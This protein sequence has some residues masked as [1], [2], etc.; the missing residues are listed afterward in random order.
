MTDMVQSMVDLIADHDGLPPRPPI[1]APL[2][3]QLGDRLVALLSEWDEGVADSLFTDNVGLDDPYDRR[4]AEARR[5]IDECCG[6]L[7][8]TRVEPESPT[9]GRL[10]IEHPSGRTLWLDLQIAPPLPPRI[11]QY[12]FE[13]EACSPKEHP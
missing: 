5:W 11:Q 9:S 1:D 4:R 2:V 6:Q 3:Q 13:L 8:V 10:A 12:G 7:Q